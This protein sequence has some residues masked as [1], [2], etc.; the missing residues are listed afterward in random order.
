MA[1]RLGLRGFNSRL[2]VLLV[3]SVLA[4][5]MGGSSYRVYNV[6]A[7]ISTAIRSDDILALYSTTPPTG[8]TLYHLELGSHIWG[9]L[10]SILFVTMV[11]SPAACT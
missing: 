11:L 9:R 8:N 5:I 3:H 6:P 1:K 7:L 2:R 10:R 4:G